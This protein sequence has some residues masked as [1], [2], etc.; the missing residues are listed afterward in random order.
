MQAV[1]NALRERLRKMH[2]G[3]PKN[4]NFADSLD[5]LKVPLYN[6]RAFFPNFYEAKDT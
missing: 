6:P 4:T 5:I 1:G 3:T 2:L